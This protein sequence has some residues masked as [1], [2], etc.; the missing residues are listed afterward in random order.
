[1]DSQKI[2][3]LKKVAESYPQSKE[4]LLR[5]INDRGSMDMFNKAIQK[6]KSPLGKMLLKKVGINE[7]VIDFISGEVR[8][9]GSTEVSK[10]Q[11]KNNSDDILSKLNRLK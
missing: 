9:G 8:G 4:G 3:E 2:N 11:I 5:A 7:D 1:M 6:A 10:P